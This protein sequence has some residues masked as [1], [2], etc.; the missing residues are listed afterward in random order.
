MSSNSK[1]LAGLLLG[2]AA[3]AAIGYLLTTEKGKE[4]L[5]DLKSAAASAGDEVKSAIEKGK[6]WANDFEEK[7][8]STT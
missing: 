4:F 6:Q 3:G 1:F 7:T 5:D 2:A 8:S